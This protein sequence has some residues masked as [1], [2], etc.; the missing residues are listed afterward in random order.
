MSIL[1]TLKTL[2]GKFTFTVP[3]KPD[4]DGK[5]HPDAGKK[6][7][8]AFEY[9]ECDTDEQAAE[10]MAEKK[11]NLKDMV[12]EALKANARSNAYQTAILP[13]KPSEVPQEDI[14]ERMVRDAIR[15]GATEEFARATVASLLAN[16]V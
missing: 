10:V 11:W 14:V 13:Y 3:D 8:K 15:M 1:E 12:N 6:I 2:V 4:A 7:E 9:Q 5:I 16:K